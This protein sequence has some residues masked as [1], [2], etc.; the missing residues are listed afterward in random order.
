[1]RSLA[2]IHDASI[3]HLSPTRFAFRPQEVVEPPAEGIQGRTRSV[4]IEV[5]D[6]AGN[7]ARLRLRL[8]FLAQEALARRRSEAEGAGEMPVSA[9]PAAASWLPGALLVPAVSA[10]GEPEEVWRILTAGP[11][12]HPAAWGEPHA[13]NPSVWMLTLPA[14]AKLRFESSGERVS[15]RAAQS[16]VEA[17]GV[18]VG[19]EGARLRFP[20]GAYPE[21]SAVSIQELTGPP[22]DPGLEAAGSAVRTEP[23]WWIPGA[24]GSLRLEFD[25]RLHRRERIGAY[26]W[27]AFKGRWTYAGGVGQAR[28]GALEIEVGELGIF[29]LFEDVAPPEPGKEDRPAAGRRMPASGWSLRIGAIDSGSGIAWDGVRIELDGRVLESEYDPDR[30]W[31]VA[32]LPGRLAPGE[33]SVRVEARDR[34]GNE[35]PSRAWSFQVSP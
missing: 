21:G 13:S 31:S 8:E 23:A 32:D 3:S 33:H 14:E 9:D 29:R 11:P 1:V 26:R 35:A 34:A 16:L 15:L 7:R 6:A 12:V 20:A 17:R 22:P 5:V 4:E 27:D 30:R 10:G 25:E 2:A 19:L 18:Q 24:T 28:G